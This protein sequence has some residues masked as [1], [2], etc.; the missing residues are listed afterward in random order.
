MDFDE[1]KY[2]NDSVLQKLDSVRRELKIKPKQITTSATQTQLINVNA[3]K[4]VR[5]Q[6]IVKDTVYTDS[7]Q[8]NPLTTIYYTIGND[9]ID[10]GLDI[11]NEQ[12]IFL[13]TKKEYKHNKKFFKRLFTLDFKK[14]TKYKYDIVNTNDAIT[15][16]NVRIIEA[17]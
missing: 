4:G 12:F 3:S 10:I 5:G 6:V 17:E 15:T 9:T 1:L 7:I 13:Y 16:T 8:Y 2:Q 11:K 14:I